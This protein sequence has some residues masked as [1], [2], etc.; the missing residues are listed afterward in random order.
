MTVKGK[1]SGA[2]AS[3]AIRQAASRVPSRAWTSMAVVAFAT[4]GTIFIVSSKAATPTANYE[5][6]AGT[7]SGNVAVVSDSG[8]SGSSAAKFGTAP[9]SSCDIP[10]RVTITAANKSTYPAY[11]IGAKVYVPMGPDPWG[12]CFPGPS[13]TGV[14][15]GT[16]LTA[17]TGPCVITTANTVIDKK[18]VNCDR[19][20]VHASGI[21]ITNSHING[22][23]YVDDTWCSGGSSFTITD[24]TV[25]T[26]DKLSR[27]LMYCNYTATRVDLS[28]GGSMAIC[29][30]CT[31]QDS[32]LHDPQEDPDGKAHNSTVRIW[33]N[34]NIIHNTLWCNVRTIMSTDG[35][36]EASGC[37]ANQT[38][39]SHDGNPPHNSTLKRNFYAAIPDGYCA[40]GGSTGGA[41]ASQVHD[42]KFIENIF[43][44]GNKP[45]NWLPNP[46]YICG[47]YGPITSMEA[48]PGNEFTGNVWDNGK[49]LQNVQN[50]WA[51]YCGGAPANCTW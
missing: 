15:D 39:Y 46:V 47:Y 42:V 36:G 44:R 12:G 28:G 7:R 4:I 29:S 41:G 10:D 14:P 6:E 45:N 3:L 37:S 32:Y 50:T 19:L 31:I 40:Y 48:L 17:Y 20:D 33:A 9:T 18:T 24:S 51:D 8:A 22:R 23:V 35:S 11:P 34:A 1:K 16:V 49:P 27:A 5:T 13:N 2:K 21:T 38:G 30:N 26:N 25:V 43:Q